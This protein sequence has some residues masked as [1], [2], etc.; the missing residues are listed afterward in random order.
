VTVG[1]VAL[2]IHDQGHGRRDRLAHQTGTLQPETL[3]VGIQGMRERIRQLGGAFYVEFTDKGTTV[4]V[5]VPLNGDT[6]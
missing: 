3:G 1:V 4:C 5:A 2:E 6:P